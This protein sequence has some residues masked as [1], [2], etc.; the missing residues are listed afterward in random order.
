M[1]VIKRLLYINTHP[2]QP[3][4]RNNLEDTNGLS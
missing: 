2:A 4:L 3:S 1:G